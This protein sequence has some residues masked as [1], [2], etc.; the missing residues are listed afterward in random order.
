MRKRNTLGVALCH[1]SQKRQRF[2]WDEKRNNAN[3]TFSSP[4]TSEMTPAVKRNNK[5]NESV[6][7]S[8]YGRKRQSPRADEKRNRRPC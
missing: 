2:H 3:L 5:R 8:G 7:P 1:A 4:T 6:T